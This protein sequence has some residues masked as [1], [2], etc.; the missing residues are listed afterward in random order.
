MT[1]EKFQEMIAIQCYSKST[2]KIYEFHIINFLKMFPNPSQENILDYLKY[3]VNHKKYS[4]SSLNLAKYSLIYYFKD[5]LQ[6]KIVVYIPKI[7][8]AKSLPQVI[9][10]ETIFKMVGITKNLKHKIVLEM[11]YSSGVRLGEIIKSEWEDVDFQNKLLRVNNGKGN[12]DRYT[13]LSNR[14]ID[15]LKKYREERYNKQS[16]YIFDSLQKPH[17]HLSGKTIQKIIKNTLKK[18][19]INLKISPHSFRHSFATNLVEKDVNIRKIQTMLGH[20]NLNT[21]NLYT[22]VANK[23]LLN[24]QNP[25]DDYTQSE[26]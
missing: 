21:T 10:K 17:T 5:V 13:I 3:L 15:D 1:Q 9:N 24:I 4:P 14:V 8:R 20:S 26:V 16:I 2:K 18:L 12:K 7:K 23:D 19:G 25:M 22:R 6:Q 11:L